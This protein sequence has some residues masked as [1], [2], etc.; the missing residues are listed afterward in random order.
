VTKKCQR[1][2]LKGKSIYFGSGFQRFQYVGFG[3]TAGPMVRQNIMAIGVGGG[4]SY[5]SQGRQKG[6][7]GSREESGKEKWEK[8]RKEGRKE[9]RKE[10]ASNKTPTR[11]H[12]QFAGGH[13]PSSQTPPLKISGTSQTSAIETNYLL[14]YLR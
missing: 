13:T 9:E 14:L 10:Q 12:S 11:T 2:Q 7:R 5:S 1:E 6:A 8:G 3:S 4:R